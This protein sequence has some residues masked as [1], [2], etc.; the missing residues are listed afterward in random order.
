[1]TVDLTDNFYYFCRIL[2]RTYGRPRT[3]GR[4]VWLTKFFFT[5]YIPVDYLIREATYNNLGSFN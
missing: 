4:D 1:M 5:W 2:R 3:Y